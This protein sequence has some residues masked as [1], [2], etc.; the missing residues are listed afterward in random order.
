M[1]VP[2]EQG[3]RWLD[4]GARYEVVVP[5]EQGMRWLYQGRKV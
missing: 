4:R 5:G 1:V 2:G 3:M